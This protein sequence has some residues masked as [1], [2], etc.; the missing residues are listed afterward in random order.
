MHFMPTL[1]NREGMSIVEVV[2]VAFIIGILCALAI[3]NFTKIRGNVYK[4]KCITNLRRIATAK[5]HWSLETEALDTA[6]PTTSQLDTYVKDGVSS[7]VCPLDAAE[8]F[9]TSYEVNNLTANPACKIKPET[10]K[11]E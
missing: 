11:L 10:H 9:S 3:P 8:G 7:L 5:E 1:R 4:D 6:T 2:I